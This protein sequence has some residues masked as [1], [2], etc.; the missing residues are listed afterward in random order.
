M[1]ELCALLNR[2]PFLWE[3]VGDLANRAEVALLQHLAGKDLFVHE[4]TRRKMAALRAELAP[5][6]PLEALL[7]GRLVLAWAD[8]SAAQ[9]E[10]FQLAAAA[11]RDV[12]LHRVLQARLDA[13]NKR[14]LAARRTL[15][16][17]RKLLA[18]TNGR[19]SAAQKEP[20]APGDKEAWAS[21]PDPAPLS[22]P[23]RRASRLETVA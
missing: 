22:L 18:K 8:V 7:V 15:A 23:R 2:Q 21:F 14:F 19:G 4:A 17:I 13:A 16:L 11:P 3:A 12:G 9:L 20:A 5:Q 10:S 6:G 1:P